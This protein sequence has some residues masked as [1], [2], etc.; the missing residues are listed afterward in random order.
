MFKLKIKDLIVEKKN[1]SGQ[2]KGRFQ[3]N[4]YF[5]R[6]GIVGGKQD[7]GRVKIVRKDMC[8]YSILNIKQFLGEKKKMEKLFKYKKV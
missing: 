1:N 5:L 3:E 6:Y 2:G 4:I 7:V 8:Y